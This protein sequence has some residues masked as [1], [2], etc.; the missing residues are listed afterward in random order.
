VLPTELEALL[1]SLP[2]TP[3][4]TGRAVVFDA[5]GTLWR[6]DVGEDLLRFL[7][8]EGHVPRSAYGQYEALLEDDHARAYAFAVEVMAGLEEA[9]VRVLAEGFFER[10]YRGRIFPAMRALLA[11]LRSQGF[12]P[13]VCTASPVWAVLPGAACLGIDASRV[14]GV[15]CERVEGRLARP[16]RAPVCCGPGKVHWL[17]QRL[18]A[19]AALA[20][21][22]GA[23]DLE[24]LAWAERALVI[25]TPDGPDNALVRAAPARKWPVWRL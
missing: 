8:F 2:A 14:I 13:W 12:E 22:N 16:V 3:S 4:S 1:A 7:A 9:Q 17:A 18:G 5:D 24:M 19:P 25:G 23:L 6:G 21:G 11:R 15:E 10:R 20:V